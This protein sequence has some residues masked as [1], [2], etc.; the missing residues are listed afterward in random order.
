MRVQ[1]SF[2]RGAGRV[3]APSQLRVRTAESP[4]APAAPPPEAAVVLPFGEPEPE[5]EPEP[6]APPR[7]PPAVVSVVVC[8]AEPSFEPAWGWG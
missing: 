2:R 4:A 7:D 3:H 1:Y 6:E 5:P 8:S